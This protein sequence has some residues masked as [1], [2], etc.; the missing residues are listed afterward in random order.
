M[1]SLDGIEPS[2][3]INS[4]HIVI[5]DTQHEI[6]C[7]RKGKRE[8]VDRVCCFAVHRSELYRS[9]RLQQI[10]KKIPGRKQV[11]KI[12]VSKRGNKPK[13]DEFCVTF[14]KFEKI[15]VLR[16]FGENPPRLVWKMNLESNKFSLKNQSRVHVNN[17]PFAPQQLPDLN[18]FDT[19]R[20]EQK[21][22]SLKKKKFDK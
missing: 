17:I 18:V 7:M 15:R 10:E 3:I 6:I 9:D 19:L 5:Q 1:S 2:G 20:G 11:G 21:E 13:R 14:V 12:F 22:I 16:C 8:P 4:A